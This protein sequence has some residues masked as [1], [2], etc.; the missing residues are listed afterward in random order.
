[1]P[2]TAISVTPA[3]MDAIPTVDLMVDCDPGTT[4]IKLGAKVG[5][6]DS[7]DGESDGEIDGE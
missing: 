6:E 4:T 2:V 1:M 7:V 5:V 3:I